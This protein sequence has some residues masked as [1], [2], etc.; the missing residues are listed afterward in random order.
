MLQNTLLRKIRKTFKVIIAVT[1]FNIV[2]ILFQKDCIVY[3]RFK[4]FLNVIIQFFYDV[5]Y[6]FDLIELLRIIELIF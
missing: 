5:I 3:S 4:I 2:F 1:F 6:K